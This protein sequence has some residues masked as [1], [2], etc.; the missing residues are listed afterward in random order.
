VLVGEERLLTSSAV[1][2][3]LRTPKTLREEKEA[4]EWAV[5]VL[6]IFGDRL[7]PRITHPAG[8]LSYANR[9]R[10]EIARALAGRPLLLLLDEP[11]A[12]MNPA[13]TLEL[14]DQ[15]AQLPSLGVGVVVIEHKLHVV[16]RICSRVI[17]LNF[18]HTIA[19]GA[20]DAVTHDPGVLQAYMGDATG[21]APVG[22]ST[23]FMARR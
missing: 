8:S 7:L 12:G 6:S 1:A 23:A 22:L 4:R 9:R 17:A 16:T 13:E 10:L 20:P 11:T 14:V 2:S 21:R 19:D 3:I 5:E 18:G 15:V